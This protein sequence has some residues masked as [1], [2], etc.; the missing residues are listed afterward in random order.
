M[1]GASQSRLP[2]PQRVRE[3]VKI[4]VIGAVPAV[5][6]SLS[7]EAPLIPGITWMLLVVA[8]YPVILYV[9]RVTTT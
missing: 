7:Q 1:V 9:A 8:L 6:G 4:V 5:A 2:S 3:A